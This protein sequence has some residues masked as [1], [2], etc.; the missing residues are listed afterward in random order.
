MTLK[1]E[2]KA[3]KSSPSYETSIKE[4]VPGVFRN[5]GRPNSKK[6]GH[7]KQP[8]NAAGEYKHHASRQ[9]PNRS[10]RRIKTR[11]CQQMIENHTDFILIPIVFSLEYF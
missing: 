4:K 3:L 7:N 5:G 10:R 2:W 8:L 1:R 9:S 6:I 11:T